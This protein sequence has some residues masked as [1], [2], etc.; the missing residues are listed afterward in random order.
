M[1]IINSS[2]FVFVTINLFKKLKL[3]YVDE[4]VAHL[5]EVEDRY[6]IALEVAA[7]ARL[8][9]I[10][11]DN[12]RIAAQAIDLL[13]RKRAGRLTFLPL[14]KILK[15]VKNKS[16]VFQRPVSTNLN[17]NS[18]FIGNAIDLIKFDSLYK[19]VFLHVFEADFFIYEENNEIE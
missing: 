6:R 8:G 15:N 19:Y 4:P 17:T 2:D 13:K 16:D 18:G 7:G 5:G 3:E 14:N 1:L 11:V 10:V 12:D 9:Q